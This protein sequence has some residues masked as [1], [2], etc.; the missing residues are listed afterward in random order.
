M[1]TAA[2]QGPSFSTLAALGAGTAH[3]AA[4]A[5][6]LAGMGLT[7]ERGPPPEQQQESVPACSQG[8]CISPGCPATM[9]LPHPVHGC[10]AQWQPP[11]RLLPA[12]G[13]AAS[14][15]FVRRRLPPHGTAPWSRLHHEHASQPCSPSPRNFLPTWLA[16]PA[17]LLHPTVLPLLRRRAPAAAAPQVKPDGVHRGL[18]GDIIK[19][20]EQRG[21]KLVGI[22]A[23]GR[24]GLPATCCWNLEHGRGQAH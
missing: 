4:S 2:R 24:W 3:R 13:S 20:F 18:V 23:R 15:W 8:A 11:C 7:S 16:A 9:L 6:A 21:Y 17:L 19:R 10:D 12:P 1:A 22:K 14:S 5:A